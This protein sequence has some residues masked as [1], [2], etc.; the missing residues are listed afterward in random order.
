MSEAFITILT[1]FGIICIAE[2]PDKTALASL[3][4]ATKYRAYQVIMGAWL[5]FLIQT[6]VAVLIGSIIHL[7]PAAPLKTASGIGFLVFAYLAYKRNEEEEKT[8]ETDASK[9]K[10]KRF[11][12]PWL[13]SFLVVF[14]AEWG[15]LTQLATAALVARTGQI[16]PIAIGATTALWTVT[17]IAV[18]VG[19]QATRFLK[20]ALL[21]NVSVGLFAAIGVIMITTAFIH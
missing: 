7:L 5:A 21:K 1:T 8:Q 20:P 14:A 15:D 13:I 11:H 6:I 17:V 3:V 10:N 2:L 4:L 19:S 18:F 9:R 12:Q 16:L